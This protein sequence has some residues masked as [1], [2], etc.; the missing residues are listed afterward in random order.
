MENFWLFEKFVV[1]LHSHS[2][3]A[4]ANA[5]YIDGCMT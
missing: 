3:N 2:D 5:N 4:A 1:P